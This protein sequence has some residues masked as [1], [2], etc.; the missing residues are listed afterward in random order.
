M[1]TKYIK[2]FFFCISIF[3]CSQLCCQ[4]NVTNNISKLEFSFGWRSIF[5]ISDF[6]NKNVSNSKAGFAK[7]GYGISLFLHK[8]VSKKTAITGGVMLH[9]FMIEPSIVNQFRNENPGF[10]FL[11]NSTS[12]HLSTLFGGIDYHFSEKKTKKGSVSF[13]NKALVGVSF[14]TSPE[15]T[16]IGVN[17][18][19]GSNKYYKQGNAKAS[20]LTFLIGAGIKYTTAKKTFMGVGVDVLFTNPSFKNIN[21]TSINNTNSNSYSKNINQRIVTI[22]LSIVLGFKL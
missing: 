8:G 16:A 9:S 19:N 10:V 20:A 5:P 13:F 18:N 11:S 21:I 17:T 4:Q 14:V 6:G 15:L 2:H 3:V 12:W 1:K 22:P 7:P